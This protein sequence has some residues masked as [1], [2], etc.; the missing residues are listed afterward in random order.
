MFETPLQ[1][2]RDVKHQGGIKTLSKTTAYY[3][4][5]RQS[6]KGHKAQPLF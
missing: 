4:N 6:I 2:L 3:V 1:H 5:A